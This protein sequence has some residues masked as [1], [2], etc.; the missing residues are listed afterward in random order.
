MG[1]FSKKTKES[2]KVEE[3]P[4]LPELPKLL[5]FSEKEEIKGELPLLPSF[6]KNS[7]G[8]KFSQD[9][10][11]KAINGRKEEER[12][13]YEDDFDEEDQTIRESPKKNIPSNNFGKIKRREIEEEPYEEK[14][15]MYEPPRKIIKREVP[16]GFEDAE[17]RII[18]SEPIFVRIDKFEENRKIFEKTKEQIYEIEKALGKI[19]TIKQEEDKELESWEQEIIDIK[20]K[21]S[22][23]ERDIFS[24]TK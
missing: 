14:I 6:P 20:E 18:E 10:I 2:E 9:T 11:K 17:R 8:E 24:K 15:Q 13:I 5:P 12:G 23:V 7:I 19:K 4:K 21:I 3:V 22:R 1:L 16:Q